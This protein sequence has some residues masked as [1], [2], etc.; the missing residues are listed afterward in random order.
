MKKI[1]KSILSINTWIWVKLAQEV[2]II[3]RD[4]I[5]TNTG[6]TFQKFTIRAGKHRCDEEYLKPLTVNGT[7][8]VVK[9]DDSAIYTSKTRENQYDTNK[10][11]GFSDGWNH[12]KNSARIGWDY[13]DG[14]LSLHAFAHVNGEM[15]YQKLTTIKPGEEVACRIRIFGSYYIFTAKGEVVAIPRATTKA[16]VDGYQLFPYFGGDET[17]S[18]Q[19]TIQI[20]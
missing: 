14:E 11:W 16:F 9:F 10:L 15:K 4:N 8:F 3:G 20:K 7:S 2:G 19:I 18:H 12:M 17:A 13:L 1:V 5:P 6:T